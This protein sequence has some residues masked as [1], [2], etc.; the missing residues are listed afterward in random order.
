LSET[1]DGFHLAL[2]SGEPPVRAKLAVGAQSFGSPIATLPLRREDHGWI[3]ERFALTDSIQFGW[4]VSSKNVPLSNPVAIT[5]AEV[6]HARRGSSLN[7]KVA[8]G[9]LAMH[10]G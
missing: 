9:L 3:G 1:E 2:V 7:A 10:A 4:V 8:N 6:S 5:W